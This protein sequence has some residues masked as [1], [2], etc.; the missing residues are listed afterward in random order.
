M[1]RAFFI[2]LSESKRLRSVAERSKIGRRVSGRFVAGMSVEDAL[3]ATKA[4]NARGMSVSVDNL[5]ENVTNLEEARHSARLYHE[6]LD[7]I[8]ARKLDAN[9]S[10]KLTHMGL[11]VDEAESRKIAA[12]L[13]S[14][15][16]RIGNF[17]RIDME[18]SPYTQKTLDIVQ[19]L[20]RQPGHANH[21][22]AVI[23][24]YLHRSEGD[25]NDL[26]QQHIRIR[27]CKGAYKE[28]PEIAF[29]DKADVDANFV[30]LMKFMLKSGVYHGIATHDPKMIEATIAFARA[31]NIPAKEFEFQMLYGVRRDL[32]EQLVKDGWGMRV[33]IPF[34]TE[35]YPYLM[36][37]LAERP[38]N[39]LFI[40]K[41]LVRR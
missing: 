37:R 39:V 31:E 41:N 29:Q 33:Y 8:D 24:A 32:Q 19:E 23:Q 6:M 40:L 4:T 2:A 18:G 5:G 12:E 3:E 9:V 26:C 35:W 38:A 25:V 17:V 36:R 14:H 13:V 21:V 34:G 11:D 7:Q 30:R 28:P 10:M 27:L 20:H 16:A 15:A 1:T 22:G